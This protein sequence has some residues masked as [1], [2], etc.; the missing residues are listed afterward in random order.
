MEFLTI[1]NTQLKVS[2]VCMGGCPL[3]GY[4]WGSTD[5]KLLLRAINTAREA[6]INFFDTADIYGLGKS[7]RLLALALKDCRDKVIIADKFGV[8][9]KNGRTFY[10]NSSQ[11][12]ETAVTTSLKNLNT[13]YIDLYQ[14]HYRDINTPIEVIVDKLEELKKRGYIRYYGLSNT[15]AEDQQE[16]LPYKGSF[17]SLQ[18]EYSLAKRNHEADI[19]ALQQSMDITPMTWG[20]LGQGI[21]TGKY[22]LD[23]RFGADDR[24]SR[25]AYDNFHGDKL[26]KN[27]RIVECMKKIAEQLGVCT[28][29][30]AIRFILDNIRDSVVLAGA[31]NPEQVAA[32]TESMGWQLS[33]AHLQELL[34]I[35]AG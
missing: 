25:E 31:K 33:Q 10:D 5:D 28:S 20:S 19:T 14:I 13:D 7:E 15:Y 6:G 2:R 17:V 21:L 27:I 4:G 22:G 18:N 30:V 1:K 26:I 3:G 12:I 34:D 11:W 16:L 8:R 23:A 9:I 24:R 32:N 35:S 29:A